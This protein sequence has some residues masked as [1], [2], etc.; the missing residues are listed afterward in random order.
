MLHKFKTEKNIYKFSN[1]IDQIYETGLIEPQKPI[2]LIAES[3]MYD[4][5]DR[6]NIDF[7][8]SEGYF[9]AGQKPYWQ[10]DKEK[11][12]IGNL[13]SKLYTNVINELLYVKD[14]TK[15]K[16]DLNIQL[17]YKIIL[18]TGFITISY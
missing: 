13:E 10:Y 8:N 14:I 1:F 18:G 5:F 4:I 16:T 9:K 6:F 3:L 15:Q 12:I 17:N 11:I 2:E 7:Y